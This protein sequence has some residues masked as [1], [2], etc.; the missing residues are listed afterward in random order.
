[1]NSSTHDIQKEAR[2]TTDKNADPGHQNGTDRLKIDSILQLFA[3][4]SI[5]FKLKTDQNPMPQSI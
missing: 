3:F 1:M 5:P 2:E 4:L